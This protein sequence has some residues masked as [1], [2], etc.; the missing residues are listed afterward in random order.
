MNGKAYDIRVATLA[1]INSSLSKWYR[2]QAGIERDE[3]GRN[4]PLCLMFD[5]ADCRY[6]ENDVE[7]ICPI[8]DLTGLNACYGTAYYSWVSHQWN[9]HNH[10]KINHF[11][12]PECAQLIADIIGGILEAKK[13]YLKSINQGASI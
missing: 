12:C 10:E 1:A 4:C 3:G 11:D 7:F 9:K 5:G 2:I 13:E 6:W 8:A